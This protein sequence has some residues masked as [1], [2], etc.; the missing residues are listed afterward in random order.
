MLCY[1]G[2]LVGDEVPHIYVHLHDDAI[3]KFG[4]VKS[5]I[6]SVGSGDEV[7]KGKN[8]PSLSKRG[9]VLPQN[10]Q[11]LTI[12]IKLESRQEC[13]SGVCIR[14]FPLFHNNRGLQKCVKRILIKLNQMTSHPHLLR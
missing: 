13:K 11:R 5:Y 1:E 12:S 14:C 7:R 6:K 4:S 2:D 3:N 8:A 9:L 10:L